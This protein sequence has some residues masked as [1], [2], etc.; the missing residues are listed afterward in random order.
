MEDIVLDH[1]HR[2]VQSDGLSAAIRLNSNTFEYA[3]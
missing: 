1:R 3:C 2:D